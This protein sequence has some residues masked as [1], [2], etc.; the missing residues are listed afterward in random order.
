MSMFDSFAGLPLHPL[1]VHAVVVL[2]PVTAL[3]V[4]A[5]AVRPAWRVAA[6]PV[7]VLAALMVVVS[8]VARQ[9][10]S[11]LQARLSGLMA[12]GA[13]VAADHGRLG[14]VL[15]L[16]A[17][18]LF[19]T[20]LLVRAARS[21]PVLNVWAVGLAVVVGLGTLGWTVMVGDSGARAVWG[22]TISS[23]TK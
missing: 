5:V 13:T 7:A 2:L 12:N 15:P 6:T 20:A 19:V 11:A 1:A 22:S 18:A 17:L 4:I 8:F 3:A 21:R 23:T 9:S 10:G 14:A 16:F